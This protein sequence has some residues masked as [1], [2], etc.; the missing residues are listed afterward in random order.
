VELPPGPVF[1]HGDAVRL[2]QVL[3]NLLTN[4]AKFTPPAERILLRLTPALAPAGM[5]EVAVEDSGYGIAPDLLPQVFE[6]FLQGEQPSDRKEGGLG[7]GLA[8]VKTIV[9]MH[10]GT[11]GAASGGPGKGST[12]TVRLPPAGEQATAVPDDSSGLR[13]M[14]GSGRILVVDDNA[15]AADTLAQLLEA[16]GYEALAVGD[17]PAALAALDGFIPV[18]AILDIGLPGMDG[19]EL[20]SRMKVDPRVPGLKFVALTGYGRDPDRERALAAAFDEHLVKPVSVERL[21]DTMKRLLQG[22]NG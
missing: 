21:F 1:V 16:I 15:D 6:L 14:R 10:G 17:G 4:A 19:Y 2:V 7:L 13:T 9:N 3:C 22:V 11:V 12:F 18:L 8:I 20:A 5:V